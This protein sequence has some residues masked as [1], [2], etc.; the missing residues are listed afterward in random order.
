MDAPDLVGCAAI[1]YAK[2]Y[3]LALQSSCSSSPSADD[4]AD[5]AAE[6]QQDANYT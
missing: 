1:N 2:A 6:V 5:D 4:A 3:G